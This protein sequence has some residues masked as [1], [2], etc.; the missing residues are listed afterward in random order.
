M[1]AVTFP[2]LTLCV[3]DS[4][5]S[6][7]TPGTRSASVVDLRDEE[8][9]RARIARPHDGRFHA[10]RFDGSAT[11]FKQLPDRADAPLP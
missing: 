2:S 4:A 7:N 9:V 6:L 5:K 3:M 1:D 10:S 8:H 11:S